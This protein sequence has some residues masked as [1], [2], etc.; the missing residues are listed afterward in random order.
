M[1]AAKRKRPDS[2]SCVGSLTNEAQGLPLILLHS[3][4]LGIRNAR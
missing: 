4:P 3:I 2:I 1:G